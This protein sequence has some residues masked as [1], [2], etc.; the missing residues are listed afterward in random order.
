M[1]SG[2]F[3]INAE[4]GLL[5]N[6]TDLD[7]L[8]FGRGSSLAGRSSF[9]VALT[10]AWGLELDDV[11]DIVDIAADVSFAFLALHFHFDSMGSNKVSS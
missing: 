6:F 8:I 3:L 1:H 4:S 11:T 9:D 5:A 10:F 2:Q 7:D